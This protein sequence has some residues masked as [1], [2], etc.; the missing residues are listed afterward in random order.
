MGS[1]LLVEN[2][3]GH[4]ASAPNTPTFAAESA[5]LSRTNS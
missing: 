1:P 3:V 5:V 4:V 2:V